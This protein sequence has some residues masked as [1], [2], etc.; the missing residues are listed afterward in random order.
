MGEGVVGGEGEFDF[1][2]GGVVSG[3]LGFDLPEGYGLVVAADVDVVVLAGAVVVVV[4][5]VSAVMV[6]AAVVVVVAGVSRPGLPSAGT[7]SWGPSLTPVLRLRLGLRNTPGPVV[8]N[9]E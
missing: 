3:G 5:V 4:G 1:A 8:I 7:K 6:G 2:V 9:N